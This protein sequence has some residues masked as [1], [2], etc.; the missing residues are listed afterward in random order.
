[1]SSQ[2]GKS[3]QDHPS[4]DRSKEDIAKA[5]DF[6]CGTHPANIH[7]KEPRGLPC[8]VFLFFVLRGSLTMGLGPLMLSFLIRSS[9]T[10]QRKI[11]K[12]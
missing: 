1:M 12:S 11:V 7:I 8:R 2:P 6:K 10:E 5:D 9:E 3:L 4:R